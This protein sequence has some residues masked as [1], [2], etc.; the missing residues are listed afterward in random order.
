VTFSAGLFNMRRAA[1]A[2]ARAA[3]RGTIAPAGG[4]TVFLI[5]YHFNDNGNN[6]N[7]DYRQNQNTSPSH[8]IT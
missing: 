4:F 6:D 8:K 1:A 7:G 5:F 3:A 2:A